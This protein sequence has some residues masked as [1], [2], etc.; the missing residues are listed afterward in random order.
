MNETRTAPRHDD[1]LAV[2]LGVAGRLLRTRADAEL[3]D[4]GIAAPALGAL[5]RLLDGPPPTQAEL[6]RRQRVEAPT[7][8][9]MVDRLARDG[10][11]ERV[12]DPE[13]RRATRVVLTGEGRA[14]AE[15]GNRVVQD[16]ETRVLD[17]LSPK[18]REVLAGLLDR[19]IDVLGP[20]AAA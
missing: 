12:P 19:V 15:R 14:V 16:L 5:L 2:R 11:V 7:M 8:C 13:D 3:S 9:R 10:L 1:L 17:V 4:L 20:G 18:E 6:A